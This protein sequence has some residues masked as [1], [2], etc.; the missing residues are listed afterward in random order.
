[1]LEVIAGTLPVTSGTVRLKGESLEG[2]PTWQRDVSLLQARDHTFPS[3]SVREALQLAEVEQVPSYVEP[4]L[5]QRMSS[6]S[7]GEKQKAAM[8]IALNSRDT[9]LLGMLDEPFSA[10]DTDAIGRITETIQQAKIDTFL[11]ALPA[12]IS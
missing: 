3:L 6:L 8:T 4:L 9:P 11:F 7:G 1:L 10:L 5:D 12:S 2:T